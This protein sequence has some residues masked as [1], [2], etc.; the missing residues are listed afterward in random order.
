MGLLIDGIIDEI[1]GI[2]D[3]IDG[4]TGGLKGLLMGLLISKWDYWGDC[5][6]YW[7]LGGIVD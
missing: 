7:S 2:I 3:H 5:G 4:I 1:N 6:N